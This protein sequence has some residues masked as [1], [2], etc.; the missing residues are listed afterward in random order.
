MVE[1]IRYKPDI[2]L[3]VKQ[4]LLFRQWLADSSLE[5]RVGCR[6]RVWL[7]HQF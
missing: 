1:P 2:I 6:K 7:C 3:A 5:P 4:K